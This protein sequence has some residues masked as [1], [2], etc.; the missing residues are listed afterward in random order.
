MEVHHIIP[1]EDKGP[2]TEDNAAPLCPSCHETYGANPT[3]RKFITEAR[4]FWH[5]VCA[6]RYATDPDRLDKIESRISKTATKDDVIGEFEQFRQWIEQRI[7]NNDET[8]RDEKEVLEALDEL[9]DKIWYDRHQG[10][11]NDDE[12]RAKTPPD[13]VE[14][15]RAE[16][17]RAGGITSTMGAGGTDDDGSDTTDLGGRAHAAQRTTDDA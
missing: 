1:Q 7:S 14:T 5:E 11:I 6:K 17:P 16:R 9:F 2:D 10:W 15:A 3:K 8:R 4:D 12:E 13:I